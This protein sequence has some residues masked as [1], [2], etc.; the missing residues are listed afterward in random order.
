MANT[1]PIKIVNPVEALRKQ[2]QNLDYQDLALPRLGTLGKYDT[3]LVAGVDKNE[4]R[5][6]NQGALK[7]LTNGLGQMLANVHAETLATPGYLAGLFEPIEEMDKG[8]SGMFLEM[9][10]NVREWGEE[11][12][13]I[14]ASQASQEAVFA[15]TNSEWWAQSA[16]QFGPT[17]ALAATAF[18]TEGATTPRLM[19]ALGKLG[20]ISSAAAKAH[21][22]LTPGSKAYN[23]FRG[24]NATISS[25]LTEGGMEAYQAFQGMMQSPE[26]LQAI[27]SGSMTEEEARQ[28]AG[29]KASKVYWNNMALGVLDMFQYS[30]I[31]KGFNLLD[32][33][34]PGIGKSLANVG[35]QMGSEALEEGWQ[36]AIGAEAEKNLRISLGSDETDTSVLEEFFAG[37][38]DTEMQKAMVQG[39][40]GGGVFTALGSA[41]NRVTKHLR[42]GYEQTRLAEISNQ[43][44]AQN[45]IRARYG[46]D[47][48][49]EYFDRD[50]QGILKLAAKQ[51]LESKDTSEIEKQNAKQTLELVDLYE[52]EQKSLTTQGVEPAVQKIIIDNSMTQRFVAKD[53]TRLSSELTGMAAEVTEE[54]PADLFSIKLLKNKAEAAKKLLKSTKDP[55]LKEAY[56]KLSKEFNTEFEE[57]KSAYR[58]ANKVKSVRD[59]K[60]S[61]DNTVKTKSEELVKREAETILIDKRAQEYSTPKG[62]ADIKKSLEEAAN[63]KTQDQ[64]ISST[65]ER[66]LQEQDSDLKAVKYQSDIANDIKD[67][68]VKEVEAIGTPE[69]FTDKKEYVDKVDAVRKKYILK[70]QKDNIKGTKSGDSLDRFI[71]NLT[72]KMAASKSIKDTLKEKKD[73]D[74][75]KKVPTNKTNSDSSTDG[76]KVIYG[77]QEVL[78]LYTEFV[79]DATKAWFNS[80]THKQIKEGITIE[81]LDFENGGD[82]VN[83]SNKNVKIVKGLHN[84][85]G[86]GVYVKVEGRIV[87]GL[88]DPNTFQINGKPLDPANTNHLAQLNSLFVNSKGQPTVDGKEFQSVHKALT[89][90]WKDIYDGNKTKLTNKEVNDAFSVYVKPNFVYLDRGSSKLSIEER[91]DIGSQF[92]EP[93]FNLKSIGASFDGVVIVKYEEVILLNFI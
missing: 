16:A 3:G 51:T 63:E 39:A 6:R 60:T 26:I 84:T 49:H 59:K 22:L 14:Y 2:V 24:I 46:K 88:Q 55:E 36:Y 4:L 57:A 54:M 32:G 35:A 28:L 73:I 93:K 19:A 12:A 47:L 37:L 85:T 42:N 13:P 52:K 50:A 53:K 27:E 89:Q 30:S 44:N 1:D 67:E 25:R 81:V 34:K 7:T 68:Y 76:N 70:A 90:I 78:Q 10:E 23:T 82:T 83:T 92:S 17:I 18:L 38:E 43:E 79:D 45:N 9:G 8:L 72:A 61:V 91:P 62:R 41:M 56:T 64:I 86:K 40:L 66:P 80:L 75:S 31:M 77:T 65:L 15:P 48:I 69:S 33:I 21:K 87:G 71:N 58:E 29:D 74:K 20:R 11:F 5:A